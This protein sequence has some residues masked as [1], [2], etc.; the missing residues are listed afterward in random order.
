MYADFIPEVRVVVPIESRDEAV[1][2]WAKETK[3]LPRFF[4]EGLEFL[5]ARPE[6]NPVGS[7]AFESYSGDSTFG[8]F[9]FEVSTER[10]V[11]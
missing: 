9:V 3:P 1:E 2:N 6:I 8:H 5:D 7:F 4:A 11:G 10:T